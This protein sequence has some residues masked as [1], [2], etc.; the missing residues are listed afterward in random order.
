MGMR[1]PRLVELKGA[2]ISLSHMLSRPVLQYFFYCSGEEPHPSDPSVAILS[3]KPCASATCGR[4]NAC[5]RDGELE[6]G[7]PFDD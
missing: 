5:V 4:Q 1:H 2:G 7:E 3:I 6:G